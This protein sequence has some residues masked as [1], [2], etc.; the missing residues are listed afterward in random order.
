[1]GIFALL[2]FVLAN[3]TLPV[4]ALLIGVFVG[5]MMSRQTVAQ[6]LGMGDGIL[7]R[8]WRIAARYVVP[9]AILAILVS[10]I[11]TNLGL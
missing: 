11:R 9:V 10:T 4:N 1:M 3:V 2:D 8:C 6:E 5:W 7:F